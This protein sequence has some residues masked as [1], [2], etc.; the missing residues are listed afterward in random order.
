M[1]FTLTICA[2]NFSKVL[3]SF[4]TVFFHFPLCL[5]G[6]EGVCNKHT[7]SQAFSALLAVLGVLRMVCVVS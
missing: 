4:Q 5:M 6:K 2:S 1:T 7:L 3:E